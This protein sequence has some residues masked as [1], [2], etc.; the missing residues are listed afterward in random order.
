MVELKATER[1]FGRKLVGWSQIMVVGWSQTLHSLA[2]F[3]VG[4]VRV[5][6]IYFLLPGFSSVVCVLSRFSCV[7]LFATLW[8]IAH[9]A[10][11]SRGFFSRQKYCSG[12]LF[13]SP[14]DLPDPG[15]EMWI[16]Y[17]LVKQILVKPSSCSKW[18]KSYL[19]TVGGDLARLSHSRVIGQ[20]H[21]H[22]ACSHPVD[23]QCSSWGQT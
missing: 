19:A 13:P 22:K 14:G 5:S 21:E 3:L 10:P 2:L 18:G 20:Y 7:Q 6:F 23:Q 4:E 8:R 15:V 17:L 16:L 9:Q 12:L 11:L 1:L